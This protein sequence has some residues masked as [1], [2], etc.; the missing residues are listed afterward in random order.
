MRIL[1]IIPT[2]V[3]AWRHGGPVYSTHGLARA[4]ARAGH[5]VHVFTTTVNGDEEL[6]VPRGQPVD[7]DGV[8]V[9]YFPIALSRRLYVSP[10]MGRALAG[11]LPGFD[12]AHLHSLFLWPPAAA[13]HFARKGGVPYFVAP[14]GM[15]VPELVTRQGRLRK[16]LWLAVIDRRNLEA[17]AG[18]HVTSELE[19]AEARRFGFRLPPLHVVPNGLDAEVFGRDPETPP[20]PRLEALFAER[21]FFLFLGRLSWKK[22]LERLIA[23]LPA[24]PAARL[25]V[26][27]NDE[28]GL[29]PR[30]Q[31]LARELGVAE[32]V[33][34]LGAVEG[35]EKVWLLRRALALV[36]PS[37]S[38]NFGNVVLEAWAAGRP[39]VV[40]PE[41]GLA[42][43]VEEAG[44]GLVAPGDPEGL[45]AAL[46]TL[47]A[48]PRAAEE[49]GRRGAVRVRERYGWDA[50]AGQVEAMYRGALGGGG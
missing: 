4:Q 28:E 13:G 45:A 1:H 21:P 2:Y 14:R 19:A 26:A 5:E 23:A 27:G 33:R 47:L 7:V 11:S 15:L 48:D 16:R 22:G 10:T 38:E 41:V 49:M 42:A 24:V 31:Q 9:T 32:G 36:L 46:T 25:A 17:A 34:F 8:L 20:S 39:A 35:A 37:L 44:A 30:L 12:V 3:P 18:L 6:D 40:T 50:I 29:L 43:E